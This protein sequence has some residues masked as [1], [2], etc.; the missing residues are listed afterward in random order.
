[1]RRVSLVLTAAISVI[2]FSQIAAAAPVPMSNWTGCYVGLNA[3]GTWGQISND[4][5]ASNAWRAVGASVPAEIHNNGS[6]T[7]D[8]SGFTGGGQVGC[9]WQHDMF[10][11]GAEADI[12]YTGLSGSRDLVVLSPPD[13]ITYHDEFRSNWLSTFR[14]VLGWAVMPTVLVYGTGGLAVAGVDTTDTLTSTPANDRNVVSASSTRTGW[15]A[16]GGVAWMFAPQWSVKLE[17]LH[18][19]LGSF[20]TTSVNSKYPGAAWTIDN[21]HRLTENIVRVG[22]NYQFYTPLP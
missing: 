21:D 3:G 14:G 10:V 6:Y 9:S 22:L 8:G 4:A 18:V 5:T 1:M 20:V 16:G 7:A 11:L 2:A 15:A 13:T 19:D 12:Q 17:Y